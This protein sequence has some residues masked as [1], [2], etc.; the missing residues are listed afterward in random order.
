VVFKNNKQQIISYYSVIFLM[1]IDNY[2]GNQEIQEILEAIQKIT[3]SKDWNVLAI[4]ESELQFILL[5][6]QAWIAYE[7]IKNKQL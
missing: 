4:A 7:G 6:K 2:P 5:D 3:E 1:N